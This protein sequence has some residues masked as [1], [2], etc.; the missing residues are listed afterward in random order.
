[1]LHAYSSSPA[2]LIT[3]LPINNENIKIIFAI[4]E[5]SNLIAINIAM[6]PSANPIKYPIVAFIV[7]VKYVN[8][9]QFYLKTK[10]EQNMNYL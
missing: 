5:N 6:Q 9:D 7:F 1:M 8:K 2:Q 4:E 10:L 3:T